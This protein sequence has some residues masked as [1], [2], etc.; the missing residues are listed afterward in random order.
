[1]FKPIAFYV[2]NLSTEH[3]QLFLESL[4][5][6]TDCS[7]GMSIDLSNTSAFSVNYLT[8]AS[9]KNNRIGR[10]TMPSIKNIRQFYAE[11]NMVVIDVTN[12]L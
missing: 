2:G 10:C 8:R 7:F 5:D 1:M 6:K 11:D 9:Y 4:E 12:E 3:K